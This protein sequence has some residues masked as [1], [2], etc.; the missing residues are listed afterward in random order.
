M[1]ESLIL[2]GASQGI[3][4]QTRRGTP[5]PNVQ[6]PVPSAFAVNLYTGTRKKYGGSWV[7][8]KPPLGYSNCAGHVWASRRTAI[9][10]DASWNKIFDD[11]GYRKIPRLEVFPGD[12]AVY[13]DADRGNYIH[14]GLVVRLDPGVSPKVPIIWVLSKWSAAAGEDYHHDNDV[15]QFEVEDSKYTIEYWTDR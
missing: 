15:R 13:V 12:L 4:V 8:R 6:D 1:F 14:V 3:V 7:F 10:D 2:A 5:I 9:L 11:D